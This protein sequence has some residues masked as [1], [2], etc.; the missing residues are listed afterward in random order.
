MKLYVI[1]P[2]YATTT[3]GDGATPLVHYFAREW[4]KM[5]HEVTAFNFMARFPRPYYWV[6]KM[7][8]HQ[9][10]SRLGMLVPT[11][12]PHDEDFKAE[13]VKVIRRTMTK[14]K[15]H[16]EY[17]STNINYALS[18]IRN[19]CEKNG[20]PD[21]FIGHWDSPCMEILPKLKQEFGKP[22]VIVLHSNQF[23][24]EKR[25]GDY[26]VEVLKQF[27]VIGFRN[28]AAQEDFERN[29]FKPAKSFICYSGVSEAFLSAGEGL[30][31]S[32]DEPIKNF[33]Y[34]GSLIARKHSIEL[35]EA[36]CKSYPEG[37]FLIKYVGD[38][39]ERANIEADY[40]AKKLG[41][42]EFTGR[43]PRESVIEHLKQA[44]VFAMI[45]K[46]EV[47]GLVYIEAMALGLIPIGSRNEGIDG[48]IV[49]GVNG[50]LCEAGNVGELVDIITK[51]KKMPK[52]ELQ[53][54]SLAARKTALDFSDSRVAEKYIDEIK[55]R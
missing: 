44:D 10:N 51:I 48:I 16:T 53:K 30:E 14:Y 38:G 32:F 23:C 13:G 18:I 20:V 40:A 33:I 11:H 21:Y 35:Y 8:Q 3:E 47:F 52:K 9:L 41:K 27:D 12:C 28:R 46:N 25:H 31:K 43:I 6:G 29:Y 55:I 22:I 39:A 42:V 24:F 15:P 26:A 54:I 4:V 45:S 19:E 37:D 7:F 34:T 50:F 49:D 5:G 36:L 2:I 1:T 17:T